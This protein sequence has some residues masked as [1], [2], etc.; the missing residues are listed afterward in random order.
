MNEGFENDYRSTIGLAAPAGRVID[1][2]TTVD[3]L[4]AWWTA[5]EGDEQVGGELRFIF[6]PSAVAVMRV[7]S[8]DASTGVHWTCLGCHVED[9]VGTQVHFDLTSLSDDQ[10]ELRFRHVGLTPQLECFSDCKSGWDHFIS[11]LQTYVETG[12]GNPN[13]SAEDLDRRAVRSAG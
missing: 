11:S 7:D 12:V 6:G 10:T 13:G 5:V 1:A 3:G 8:V 4:A 2:L 9:W